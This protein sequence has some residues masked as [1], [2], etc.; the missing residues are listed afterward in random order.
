MYQKIDESFVDKQISMARQGMQQ[1]RQDREDECWKPKAAQAMAGGH[2]GSI[3]AA[4]QYQNQAASMKDKS[5]IDSQLDQQAAMLAE[6][7]EMINGL[8]GELLAVLNHDPRE[9]P[10][11]ETAPANPISCELE[12]HLA[13]RNDQLRDELTC[14]REIRRLLCL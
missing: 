13:R 8:T 12:G 10:K 6:L 4:R 3:A 9:Q 14:L 5:P 7:G 1:Q 2:I 11:P